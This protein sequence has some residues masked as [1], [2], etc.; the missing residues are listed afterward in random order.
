M[1][2]EY[3]ITGDG[4]YNTL[5]EHP[6]SLGLQIGDIEWKRG[7]INFKG[8]EKQLDSFID[9]LIQDETYFKFR[10]VFEKH[11]YY[12]LERIDLL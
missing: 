7:V 4:Y 5:T 9:L 6:L 12:K 8:T 3:I 11:E 1:V 10:D 2:K